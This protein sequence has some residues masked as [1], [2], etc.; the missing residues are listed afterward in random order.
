MEDGLGRVRAAG[1]EV[2]PLA[3]QLLGQFGGAQL[4]GGGDDRVGREVGD[5][6]AGEDQEVALGAAA[7]A[8]HDR[9]GVG[10]L[11]D[12]LC[13]G[14]VVDDLAEWAVG[15]RVLAGYRGP[16][17]V[18]VGDPDAGAG[19]LH[20]SADRFGDGGGPVA[21]VPAVHQSW[22]GRPFAAARRAVSSCTAS[23]TM[24]AAPGVART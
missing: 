11:A 13:R 6:A 10:P 22:T 18:V 20:A 9:E 21:T 17:D 12:D 16:V 1:G 23:S 3:A 15:P 14:A 7:A 8:G 5:V 2:V 24:R 19:F 4:H